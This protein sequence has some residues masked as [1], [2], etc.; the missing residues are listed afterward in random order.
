MLFS[1]TTAFVSIDR[2]IVGAVLIEDKLR[3][4]ARDA[5]SKIKAMGIHIIML[6]GDND[7][8]AKKLLM[9][10]VLTNTMLICSHK[11]RFQ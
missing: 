4:G 10:L 1:S 7:K 3:E 9:N 8:I 6:T 5:I 11:R 2:Q